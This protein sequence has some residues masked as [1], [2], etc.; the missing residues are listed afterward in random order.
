MFEACWR[1]PREVPTSK[2][3]SRLSP[4]Y[5]HHQRPEEES[6]PRA[7]GY[8]DTQFYCK[9]ITRNSSCGLLRESHRRNRLASRRTPT[10]TKDDVSTSCISAGAPAASSLIFKQLERT[11]QLIAGYALQDRSER[12]S[13]LAAVGRPFSSKID[14]G[15]RLAIVIAHDEA[16]P[17]Q[18]RVWIVDGPGR[19]RGLV[20]LEQN[21]RA[22]RH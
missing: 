2:L 11:V 13:I 7:S 22:R 3:K 9:S 12:S 21:F 6:A 17:I 14:A 20:C 4:P 1:R 15:E 18:L 16:G 10:S 19:T 8:K 5:R